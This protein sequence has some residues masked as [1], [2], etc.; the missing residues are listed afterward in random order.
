MEIVDVLSELSV[1]QMLNLAA[2]FVTLL[3]IITK[4]KL[5]GLFL[6]LVFLIVFE[7]F[8]ARY[9]ADRYK[10]NELIYN[11]ICH[12]SIFFYYLILRPKSNRW[13][14]DLLFIAWV[15]SAILIIISTTGFYEVNSFSYLLGLSYMGFL[16]LRHCFQKLFQEKYQDFFL[17]EVTW[18]SIGL[19][20]FYF[21]SFPILSN[22]RALVINNDINAGFGDLL[23]IG[24]VFL[25]GGYL[26]AALVIMYNTKFLRY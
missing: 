25:S 19:L 3:V 8:V 20:A 24:N 2:F 23:Q 11:L 22:L 16:A 10:S 13:I 12:G 26:A 14:F 15:L 9:F 21:C 6:L 18:L 5:N 7:V 1:F 4:R 17:D